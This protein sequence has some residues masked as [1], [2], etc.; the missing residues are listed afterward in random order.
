MLDSVMGKRMK[1]WRNNALDQNQRSHGLSSDHYDCDG[2]NFG[3]N[4]DFCSPK[5]DRNV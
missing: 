5:V 2:N 4:D 1:P 3:H